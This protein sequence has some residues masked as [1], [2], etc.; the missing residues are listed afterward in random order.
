MVRRAGCVQT[1]AYT[2]AVDVRRGTARRKP[3][4]RA[5]S[6]RSCLC[7]RASQVYTPITL[8]DWLPDDVKTFL[9]AIFATLWR[10]ER[11]LIS[12]EKRLQDG[13]ITKDTIVKYAP[14]V[15]QVAEALDQIQV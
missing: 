6:Q 5:R 3:R 12:T 11:K 9:S 7:C 4:K 13:H 8:G 2:A 1:R 15:K 14:I 10:V